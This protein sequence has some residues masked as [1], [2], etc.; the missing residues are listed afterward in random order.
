M[1]CTNDAHQSLRSSW[2]HCTRWSSSLSGPKQQ[3]HL[4]SN[5][6]SPAWMRLPHGSFFSQIA[7]K[8]Y[9][10]EGILSILGNGIPYRLSRKWCLTILGAVC[11]NTLSNL[12]KIV[13]VSRP[14]PHHLYLCAPYH[15]ST[16]LTGSND[17][18]G[19]LQPN[20]AISFLA[21]ASA[22]ALKLNR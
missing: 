1:P 21:M 14:T 5:Q 12:W 4:S 10:I 8:T 6:G 18:S 9:A 3:G 13:G 11:T 20:S 19:N 22:S 16:L 17:T 7:R 15:N 2:T